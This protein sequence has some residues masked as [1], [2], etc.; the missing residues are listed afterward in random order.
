VQ[1]VKVNP[2]NIQ[3]FDQQTIT[4]FVEHVSTFRGVVKNTGLPRRMW[5]DSWLLVNWET[6]IRSGD[7]FSIR[8]TD[9]D[10]AGW[11]W[12]VESKTQKRGWRRLRDSVAKV[13]AEFIAW[14]SSRERIWPGYKPRHFYRAFS[15]L[16]DSVGVE[17]SA[18]W[19]RRGSA[20]EVDKLHPGS[21]WKFLRHSVPELFEK[22][23]RVDKIVEERPLLPPE[24]E[25]K[26]FRPTVKK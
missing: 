21:G 15:E 8:P 2:L 17:G 7:M 23:Y 3:G 22:H 26:V 19:I 20:S 4:K 18:R 16:C 24:I 25:A 6:A 10:R 14:D 9:F 12:I 1:E 5:W 11:L 13:L